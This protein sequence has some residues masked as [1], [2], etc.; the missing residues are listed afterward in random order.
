MTKSDIEKLSGY[1]EN[2]LIDLECLTDECISGEFK[3][4]EKK[5]VNVD[6]VVDKI[7]QTVLYP[8]NSRCN[9]IKIKSTKNGET[10]TILTN[11]EK[12]KAEIIN[13]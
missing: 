7:A 6:N 3:I 11:L 2:Q 10:Y 8:G 9:K 4:I 12:E 13:K 1:R 5:E